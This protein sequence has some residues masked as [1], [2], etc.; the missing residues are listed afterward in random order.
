MFSEQ[1]ARRTPRWRD[2]KG[3]SVSVD[4]AL[5][6]EGSVG[7]VSLER[8]GHRT[9]RDLAGARC[10]EVVQALALVVAILI[11]PLADTRPLP[12]VS[13]PPPPVPP[14]P[15]SPRPEQP[16]FVLAGSEFMLEGGFAPG[17]NPGFRL[18]GGVIKRSPAT[19]VSS[20]RLSAFHAASGTV[21]A[22]GGAFAN[23][24]LTG[25]RA[26][27]CSFGFAAGAFRGVPCLFGEAGV[28]AA[29]GEH[30]E[31]SHSENV[32]WVALGPALRA[33][34]S[35]AKVLFV[36]LEAGGVVPL[37]TYS[38]RFVDEPPLFETPKIAG[39][40]AVGLG[41]RFP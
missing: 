14:V 34:A 39:E 38:F 37:T 36:E 13:P 5:T 28:L 31:R 18:F 20:L 4:V 2:S 27:L 6:P 21:S 41:A 9:E 12:V 19:V 23:F 1:V 3:L 29:D 11:D 26:E 30:P 15:P 7:R 8:D 35:F 10:D 16:W 24:A 33:S 17:L 32:A 25:G 40:F 22:D